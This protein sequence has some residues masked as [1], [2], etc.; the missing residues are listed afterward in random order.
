MF[1]RLA[2]F[3]RW[4]VANATK[5]GY[6]SLSLLTLADGTG[7]PI[8]AELSVLSLVTLVRRGDIR[9][10]PAIL[11]AAT[12]NSVGSLVPIALG[13]L[14]VSR[15]VHRLVPASEVQRQRLETWVTGYAVLAVV[16]SRVTGILRVAILVTAGLLMVPMAILLPSLYAGA[17]LW[18]AFGFEAVRQGGVR[19]GKI[20]EGVAER[21]TDVTLVLSVLLVLV[22]VYQGARW[23]R[24]RGKRR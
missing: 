22:V 11:L 19:V 10:W 4:V 13:R 18:L 8:P 2:P 5:H 7:L 21:L 23:K 16:I 20:R 14:K 17:V 15:F 6:F 1:A 3:F 12:A 24:R 9:L